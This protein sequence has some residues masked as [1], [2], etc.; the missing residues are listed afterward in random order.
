MSGFLFSAF[1]YLFAAVIA[2]TLSK[3]LGLGSV[4]GYL[5]AGLFIG[6]VLGLV[7]AET[8]ELQ[9]FAE[10]GIVMML[11][12]VGLELEPR[13]LWSMRNKLLGLGG[14]QVLL[15]ILLTA[16]AVIALEQDWRVALII[17]MIV[18]ISSTTMVLQSFEEIGVSNTPGGR[19]AFAVLLFQD[20]I[21][22]PMLAIIPLLALPELLAAQSGE[23]AS[24]TTGSEFNLVRNLD[25]WSYALVIVV[26]IASVILAGNYLS[27]PLF[28]FIASTGLREAFTAAAL[29]L[30]VGIAALMLL[31]GLSPA[32]G[33]FLAGVVLATSEF[34]HE[35]ETDI[36]PFKGLLVGLF[37][38]TVGAGIQLP[39]LSENLGLV[40]G[41]TLGA[42]FIKFAVL[43][44]LARVYGIRGS[45]GWLF[46]LS[47]PQMSAFGFVLLAYS[48]QN[49]ALPADLVPVLSLVIALSMFLTPLC[50]IL[51]Q[52]V[53]APYY[54]REGE[55]RESDVVDEQGPVIIAG[56]G[57]FGQI[58]SRLLRASG[59]PTV[60]LDREPGQIEMMR[61]VGIKSYFGD[62]SRLDLLRTAGIEQANMFVVAIDSPDEAVVLVRNVR[63]LYPDLHIL[64]RAY[65]RGHLYRLRDA[66]ADV[67]V[68][69]TYHSALELGTEVLKY[70]GVHPYKAERYK[71]AFAA[72]E[73]EARQRLFE[74]WS[75]GSEGDRFNKNFRETFMQLEE[76][77]TDV[78]KRDRADGHS[79]SE[80]GWTPPPKP[81]E[82]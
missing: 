10:F 63:A 51:F 70:A 32:L 29:T 73:Q 9:H 75:E 74:V 25:G 36:E 33:T 39:V 24:A 77:L 56:I 65:D 58:V 57:R 26:S 76:V 3:R 2:V 6:P 11:F 81:T 68:I 48:V 21:V 16:A 23:L 82:N 20:I 14:L 80:R 27:R 15:T 53:I 38:I 46:S 30:M 7:G 35:L 49:K 61:Q 59:F 67:A 37:F 4:L 22:I 17:G 45:D 1:I 71:N 44:L 13:V 66:G 8:E 34:R 79:R 40:F 55:D 47:L 78:M 18:A 28:R 43:L 52:R 41:L 19:S 12:L 5:I 64:A 31:V 50:F 54:Q 62:A 69:E 60:V 72:A 42:M